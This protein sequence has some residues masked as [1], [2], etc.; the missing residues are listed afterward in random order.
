MET[1]IASTGKSYAI[2]LDKTIIQVRK[3]NGIDI[4]ASCEQGGC[5]T[6]ILRILEGEPG[7]Q[8]MYFTNEE[9]AKNDQF[10]PCCSRAR[11]NVLVLDL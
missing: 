4:L 9:H 8:E 7:H 3:N 6:R 5:E 2:S 11:S 10:T 1:P